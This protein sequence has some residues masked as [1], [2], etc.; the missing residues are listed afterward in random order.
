MIHHTYITYYQRTTPL[1]LRSKGQGDV[2]YDLRRTLI[3][4]WVKL[5]KVKVR[6]ESLNLMEVGGGGFVLFGQLSLNYYL[7]P[8]RLC[9]F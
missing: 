9:N 6:L 2:A 1:T 7:E 8:W 5:S 3:D 4:F